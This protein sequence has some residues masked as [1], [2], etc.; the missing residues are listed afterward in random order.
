MRKVLALCFT[1]VLLT[2]PTLAKA[3]VQAAEQAALAWL[4]MIDNA[5]YQQAWENA[6]PLLQ[7]P[8]SSAMLQRTISLSRRD[9]GAAQARRRVRVSQYTSMPGAPRGDYKEFTFQTR[10]EN[11]P[12]VMEVVT[13]HLE[14]GTWRVSG[15]YIQ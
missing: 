9:L 11:N 4:A 13:P 10:F 14:N 5:E 2:L 6:S 12:R 1:V 3:S 15:Y 8:L 7:A